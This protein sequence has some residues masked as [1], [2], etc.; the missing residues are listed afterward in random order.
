MDLFIDNNAQDLMSL[1]LELFAIYVRAPQRSIVSLNSLSS[2]ALQAL[3]LE[4]VPVLLKVSSEVVDGQA[5]Q[6]QQQ[7]SSPYTIM[8]EISRACYLE[9]IL[10][11]KVDS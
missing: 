9:D 3:K 10:F 5:K 6:I 2:S 8:Q 11:G 7:T 1:S 4:K